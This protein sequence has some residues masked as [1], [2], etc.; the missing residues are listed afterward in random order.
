M[1]NEK[2]KK[3]QSEFEEM[4]GAGCN[5]RAQAGGP[6]HGAGAGG[7]GGQWSRGPSPQVGHLANI[8]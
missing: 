7:A 1:E 4:L 6:A 2:K 5:G 3:N 8:T